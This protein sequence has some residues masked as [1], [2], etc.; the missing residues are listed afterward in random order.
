MDVELEHFFTFFS[1]N[2]CLNAYVN[3][4]ESEY[5]FVTPFPLIAQEYNQRKTKENL[6]LPQL[7]TEFLCLILYT[8]INFKIQ[9]EY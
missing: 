6:T 5:I 3:V 2:E 9:N 7:I 4:I 1:E 8:L